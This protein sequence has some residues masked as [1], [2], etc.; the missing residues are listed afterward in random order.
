MLLCC[1]KV[2]FTG[3]NS[4]LRCVIVVKPKQRWNIPC[5]CGVWTNASFSL[6]W[7]VYQYCFSMGKKQLTSAAFNILIFK[8]SKTPPF[9][10]VFP[11]F[12]FGTRNNEEFTLNENLSHL[13]YIRNVFVV[14]YCSGP[15]EIS[16]SW[17]SSV[18]DNSNKR[19]A[20]CC[21]LQLKLQTVESA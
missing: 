7:R 20:P 14:R 10:S 9:G 6:C 11:P 17:L 8:Y 12:L 4:L 21:T 19:E 15:A 3:Q 13:H 5:K 18:I 16:C 2:E 1:I